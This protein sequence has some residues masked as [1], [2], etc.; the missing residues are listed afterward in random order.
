MITYDPVLMTADI[1]LVDPGNGPL[2]YSL[3]VFL[4]LLGIMSVILLA[5]QLKI[6]L[7]RRS[8]V[9]KFSNLFEQTTNPLLLIDENKIS[10]CNQSA[11][12]LFRA[13]KKSDLVGKS[14]GMLI[15]CERG[16][17]EPAARQ[18]KTIID[19]TLKG[20][21]GSPSKELRFKRLD[22]SI[23]DGI[24]SPVSI[25]SNG[26]TIIQLIIQDITEKK[27][28]EQDL[29]RKSQMMGLLLGMSEFEAY[30]RE[31]LQ[32]YLLDSS[33]ALTNSPNGFILLLDESMKHA[34]FLSNCGPEF[35][36]SRARKI[37][38]P[39]TLNEDSTLGKILITGKAALVNEQISID[40][41]LPESM[42]KGKIQ[43]RRFM[44][45]PIIH[46]ESV[47]G[48]VG[49]GDKAGDYDDEDLKQL[50]VLI[51][52][53]WQII[54]RHDVEKSLKIN[55]TRYEEAENLARMGHWEWDIS[56]N[57]VEWSDEVYRMYGFEPGEV[58]PCRKF[59]L[60]HAHPDD[61]RKLFYPKLHDRK[62]TIINTSYRIITQRKRIKSVRERIRLELSKENRPVRAFGIVMDV[63]E[64]VEQQKKLFQAEKLRTE[65]DLAKEA[66]ESSEKTKSLFLANMSHEIRTPMNAILGMCYL[67]ED[68]TDNPA[69]LDYLKKI[70][71]VAKSLLRLINDILDLS[72][73]ESGR[74]DLENL[75][76]SVEDVMKEVINVTK[77]KKTQTGVELHTYLGADIPD[78]VK[79]D[80]FRL[81]QVL[82][83]LMS[84]AIKFT[85]EGDVL[86]SVE[87]LEY[88]EKKVFL[89]FSVKDTGI[90][91]SEENRKKMFQVFTQADESTTRRF[92]GTGL[93]LAVTKQLVELMG[94]TIEIESEVGIGS[95]FICRIPLGFVKGSRTRK[96]V[97]VPDPSL[98]G[99]K[100]LAADDNPTAR[101]IIF[102]LLE[103]M[104]FQTHV[105]ESGLKAIDEFR[106]AEID[107]D[108]FG[109][110]ILD[111]DMPGMSGVETV[112]ALKKEFSLDKQRLILVTSRDKNKVE[113]K[114]MAMGFSKVLTKPFQPS[115]LFNTIM[116][117]F[118]HENPISRESSNVALSTYSFEGSHI[119]LVEDN[120]INQ[121]VAEKILKKLDIRIS[122]AQNGQ[123]AIQ[124]IKT[125]HYDLILMDLQMPVMGGLEATRE[126]RKL[127]LPGL[128]ELPILA[129]TAH[130]MKSD[131]DRCLKAGMNGHISKPFEPSDLCRTLARWLEA[132]ETIT[133]SNENPEITDLF[134]LDVPGIDMDTARRLL[135]NNSDLFRKLLLKFI[136]GYTEAPGKITDLIASED[137]ESA[138]RMAH[139]IKSVAGSLG[140]TEL[141]V[142]SADLEH[143]LG[144]DE[145]ISLGQLEDFSNSLRKVVDGLQAN[146]YLN[147]DSAEPELPQGDIEDL[148]KH[149]DEMQDALKEFKPKPCK[150]LLKEIN[151]WSWPDAFAKDLDDLEQLIKRYRFQE[152]L[153]VQQSFVDKL[154]LTLK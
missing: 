15:V 88:D 150:D 114:E 42:P 103:P 105:V 14:P 26:K 35:A 32:Q 13:S 147:S 58:T 149:L 47:Y 70:D 97:F 99:L 143:T 118:G 50:T 108:P 121:E 69:T 96:N 5:W 8:L 135:S 83:N 129:M 107:R 98:K 51:N 85:E 24:L 115:V 117:A 16:N 148:K 36:L 133:M 154:A 73:I 130:A 76:F 74:L 126:I 132:K 116:D 18:I 87:C 151:N 38:D 29:T 55:E 141:Q 67:A 11:V 28:I 136:D 120:E 49:V 142:C 4:I 102:S 145:D 131:K 90:G 21:K 81:E 113:K 33:I 79:G 63:T 77:V 12:E 134:T 112:K 57:V 110:L 2:V 111:R 137:I 20:S 61:T 52:S 34:S 25:N 92:G 65:A 39:I 1:G 128:D 101:K 40:C 30:D 23:F 22:G 138:H 7:N 144:R 10:E 109:L 95:N 94:G 54:M 45:A 91:I 71:R 68:S 100:I 72:K 78:R 80:P 60:A 84:N 140:M 153:E 53:A 89:R 44:A 48:L 41:P 119:L 125:N 127:D 6:L 122:L 93:G 43:M 86:L 62:S 31:S 56:E 37:N 82:T 104:G 59:V 19:E 75:E 139:S 152:A 9:E 124:M 27:Q 123:E 64:T 3:L 17:S 66:A 46:S 106:K 146:S